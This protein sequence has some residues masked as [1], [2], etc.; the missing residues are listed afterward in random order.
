VVIWDTGCLGATDFINLTG[1]TF[2]GG[3]LII[4][5]WRTVNFDNRAIM[6]FPQPESGTSQSML[7]SLYM[8]EM[9]DCDTD[10]TRL[11]S[12]PSENPTGEQSDICGGIS[13]TGMVDNRRDIQGVRNIEASTYISDP[14]SAIDVRYDANNINNSPL[15]DN[16]VTAVVAGNMTSLSNDGDIKVF[17]GD[18]QS[19]GSLVTDNNIYVTRKSSSDIQ[20]SAYVA[21]INTGDA[22]TQN[23]IV[24]NSTQN[25]SAN[26]SATTYINVLQSADINTNV[27]ASNLQMENNATSI[28][29]NQAAQMVGSTNASSINT[30]NGNVQNGGSTTGY[31]LVAGRMNIEGN[32][33]TSGNMRTND[34][35]SFAGGVSTS[36][37]DITNGSNSAQ[38]QNGGD[39]PR[40]DD[41]ARCQAGYLGFTNTTACMNFLAGN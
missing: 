22:T 18:V 21:L 25:I 7:T 34:G 6:R 16:E 1:D 31:Q 33:S 35:A 12:I 17:E 38:C 5:V 36:R 14:Q 41:L 32:L 2:V 26:I 40:R 8:G 29:V 30:N 20:P 10:A 24:T 27:V 19:S 39:C 15:L 28:T 4:P 9:H 11:I 37:I 3:S 23:M 13:D